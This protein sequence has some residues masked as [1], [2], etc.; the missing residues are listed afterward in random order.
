MKVFVPFLLMLAL[1]V[2]VVLAWAIRNSRGPANP[3]RD[4]ER[5]QERL[6][7]QQERF[8]RQ[9]SWRFWHDIFK[10]R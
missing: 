4:L 1:V 5:R 10:G 7:R 9:Q 8:Y 2:A 6:M 3:R